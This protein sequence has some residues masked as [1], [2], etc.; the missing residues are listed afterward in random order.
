MKTKLRKKKKKNPLSEKK[1]EVLTIQFH[2]FGNKTEETLQIA[3]ICHYFSLTRTT[4]HYNKSRLEKQISTED[5]NIACIG[6][7]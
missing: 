5:V 7:S 3:K 6:V 2:N 1:F 4:I